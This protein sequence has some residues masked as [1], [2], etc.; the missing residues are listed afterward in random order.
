LAAP[1]SSAQLLQRLRAINRQAAG[2]EEEVED[3]AWALTMMRDLARILRR[4]PPSAT[5]AGGLTSADILAVFAQRVPHH[6][7]LRTYQRRHALW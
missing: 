4:P 3:E 2:E 5:A 6:R 1:A 7:C